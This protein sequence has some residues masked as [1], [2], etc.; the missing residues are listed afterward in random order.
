MLF[1]R[2]CSFL[3]QGT[4]VKVGQDSLT[5]LFAHCSFKFAQG[6][7]P[8][9][10]NVRTQFPNPSPDQSPLFF[11]VPSSSLLLISVLNSGAAPITTSPCSAAR[12]LGELAEFP[13][14]QLI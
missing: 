11:I 6:V 9:L 12:R 14:I 13:P 7:E 5:S 4:T 2:S 8:E 10:T 1:V 3:F